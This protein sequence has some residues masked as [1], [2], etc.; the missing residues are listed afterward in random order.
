MFTFHADIAIP[1]LWGDSRF[2]KSRWGTV[3]LM[4]GANGSG[5]TLLAEQLAQQLQEAGN[6]TVY[7]RVERIG[8]SG[9]GIP[10]GILKR[11]TERPDIKEN[12]ETVL[13]E[14]F[15]KTMYLA[16]EEGELVPRVRT[17]AT[18]A[19]YNVRDG[20]CHG[21][22]EIITL[23]TALYDD[24]HDVLILDEP[25]MHLHPQ[26]QA[27]FLSEIRRQAERGKVF[28][29]IT[30]SPYFIDIRT[31]EDLQSIILCHRDALPTH[32]EKI[33]G[34]HE[35]LL[36]KFLP[37]FN[38]HHK[39]FFFSDV[40]VFVE[41]YTDQQI[42]TLLLEKIS[43]PMNTSGISVIDVG[44]KDELGVFFIL[45][46]ELGTPAN[47]IADLDALFRG[48]LRDVLC[49]DGRP[50]LYLRDRRIAE[51]LRD[52]LSRLE[53]SLVNFGEILNEAEPQPGRFGKFIT[54]IQGFYN[55]A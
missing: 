2:K 28:F 40:P 52:A 46:A 24:S 8:D 47:I 7:L 11:L 22:R 35:W 36:K 21:L 48:K 18:G 13:S 51:S 12:I 6:R 32:I 33:T 4:V 39:Q 15:R 42:V 10:E 14:M 44:G 5:K 27:F 3:N 43:P 16:E 31:L 45:C 23:L 20:E 53:R 19:E 29:I 25:E 38:T 41:G 9:S 17:L 54:R 30:H 50:D 49:A 26:F 1:I 55:G 37:R 34:E